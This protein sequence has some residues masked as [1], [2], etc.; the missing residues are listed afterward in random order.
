MQASR[1]IQRPLGEAERRGLALPRRCATLRREYRE[2]KERGP[3]NRMALVEEWKQTH[4][5]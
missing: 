1:V 3:M 5:A 2:F 4:A